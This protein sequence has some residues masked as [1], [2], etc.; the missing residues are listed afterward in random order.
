MRQGIWK[1]ATVFRAT[2]ALSAAVTAM[3]VSLQTAVVSAAE[4]ATPTVPTV[5]FLSLDDY[6]S[7]FGRE[8]AAEIQPTTG[9]EVFRTTSGKLIS[10][11]SGKALA[12]QRDPGG[13]TPWYQALWADT[14][15]RGTYVP[16]R[17]GDANI[18]YSHYASRHNL[19]TSA[20]FRVI[21]NTSKPIVDQGAHIEYQ[22]LLTDLSNG[23]IKIKVRMVT[24]AANRTDD[25]RYVSPDGRN[26]GTITAYCEGVTKCPAWVNQIT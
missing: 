3:T 12:P 10:T 25:G 8:A 2:L 16:T 7:M 6:A 24:Q 1:L 22:A 13:S 17:F 11:D 21:R 5:A 26:I 18:G 20:P 9:P 15:K 4:A 19:I 14:D 23:S